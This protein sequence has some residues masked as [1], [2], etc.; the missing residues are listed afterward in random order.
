[1]SLRQDVSLPIAARRATARAAD[2]TGSSS[3]AAGVAHCAAIAELPDGEGGDNELAEEDETS[4]RE[5]VER[6]RGTRYE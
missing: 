1:M 4:L 5:L 2:V 3:A 6:S